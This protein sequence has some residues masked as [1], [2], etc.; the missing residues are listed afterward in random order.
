MSQAGIINIPQVV[1][2]SYVANIGSAAPAGGVLNILGGV[3]ITTSASGNTITINAISS[4]FT[5]NSVTPLA[6][7]NPIQIVSENGYICGGVGTT[8]FTLPLAASIGNT[9]VIISNTSKF[10]ILENAG[11]QMQIGN[12][13]STAGSG[14]ITSTATGDKVEFTYIA[15]NL[16]METSMQGNPIII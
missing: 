10:Q 15:N 11:Q 8:T 16:W 9:F 1:A 6:P 12:I 7:A 14:S 3:G 5:W 4:G 13:Q 2:E